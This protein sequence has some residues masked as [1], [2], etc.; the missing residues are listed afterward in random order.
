MYQKR[1]ISNHTQLCGFSHSI[2]GKIYKLRIYILLTVEGVRWRHKKT[3]WRSL[4]SK[5]GLGDDVN[6]L[7]ESVRRNPKATLGISAG[8]LGS[9]LAAEQL[10]NPTYEADQMVGKPETT[11]V[12]AREAEAAQLIVKPPERFQAKEYQSYGSIENFPERHRIPADIPV[13]EYP[14]Y[15]RERILEWNPNINPNSPYFDQTVQRVA[16]NVTG[17]RFIFK[18]RSEGALER[19]NE[20]D[21]IVGMLNQV[22]QESYR[23][24][25]RDYFDSQIELNNFGVNEARQII[26]NLPKNWYAAE[27]G[28]TYRVADVL[29]REYGDLFTSLEDE[30]KAMVMQGIV[31]ANPNAHYGTHGIGG[32]EIPIEDRYVI[33]KSNNLEISSL[34]LPHRDLLAQN[35]LNPDYDNLAYNGQ[36]FVSR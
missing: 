4:L 34:L 1:H 18:K 20:M 27:V 24:T 32:V 21:Q 8:L 13:S 19:Y 30:R 2:R 3:L 35:L 12:D 14:Q 17:A 7:I 31:D 6:R 28:E 26:E 29:A 33:S 22:P 23:N 16:N 9:A 11:Q 10:P 25:L 5:M 36:K 15:V